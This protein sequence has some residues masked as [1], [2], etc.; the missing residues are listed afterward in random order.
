MI[1]IH[2]SVDTKIAHVLITQRSE[3]VPQEAL[4]GI[5]TPLPVSFLDTPS[6]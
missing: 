4:N 1:A 3:L 2:D 6:L 5:F